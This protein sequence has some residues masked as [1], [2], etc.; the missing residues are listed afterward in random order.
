MVPTYSVLSGL[1]TWKQ[2][3]HLFFRRRVGAE[4]FAIT[5]VAMGVVLKAHAKAPDA[6]VNFIDRDTSTWQL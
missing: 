6:E 1:K 5:L 2:F 4:C 3:V